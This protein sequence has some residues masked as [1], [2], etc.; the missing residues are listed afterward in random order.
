MTH[1]PDAALLVLALLAGAQ[2]ASA[3]DPQPITVTARPAVA[4]PRTPIKFFGTTVA[5][6]KRFDVTI[7]IVFAPS[8]ERMARR[9]RVD[10]TGAYALTIATLHT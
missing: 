4:L 1:H 9:V 8:G 7:T 5:D 3:Q 6:G 10:S 2:P